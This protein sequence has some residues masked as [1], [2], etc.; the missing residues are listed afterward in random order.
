[1]SFHLS[2]ED[3]RIEDGHKLVARLRR[4]N[5][6]LQDAEI[7]LNQYLGNDNG[8][9]QWEGVNFSESAENVH[10]AIEGGGEVPV[11]RAR[12]ANV[13]GEYLDADVNLSERIENIDGRF[14]FQ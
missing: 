11:L 8:H 13:D 9:F 7:D 6:E 2:A 3:I 12:L 5:G 1:M 10:F 14:E 4:D